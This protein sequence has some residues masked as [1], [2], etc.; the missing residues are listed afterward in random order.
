MA[1]LA[2]GVQVLEDFPVAA[3]QD[4]NVSN[5]PPGPIIHPPRE[6]GL[7]LVKPDGGAR[8]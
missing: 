5:N 8:G 4:R 7:V 6:G 3:R 1:I 2:D